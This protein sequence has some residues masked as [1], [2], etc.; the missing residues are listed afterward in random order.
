MIA[1]GR[2]GRGGK[3]QGGKCFNDLHSTDI[4][5]N[6]AISPLKD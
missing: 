6:S 1:G 5:T 2:G 4:F 3:V